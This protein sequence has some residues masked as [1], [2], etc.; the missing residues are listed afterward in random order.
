MVPPLCSYQ[1]VFDSH[2]LKIPP[3]PNM[4]RLVVVILLLGC[5]YVTCSHVS[6][7]KSVSCC[8]VVVML[9][10]VVLAHVEW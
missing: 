6:P 2:D 4:Y 1:A 8:P 10:D 5:S 9:V 7:C 3:I